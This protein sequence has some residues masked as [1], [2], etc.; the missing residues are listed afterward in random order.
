MISNLPSSW[1][2]IPLSKVCEINPRTKSVLKSDDLVSFVPMAAVSEHSGSIVSGETRPLG[3]VRKGFTPFQDGDVLFAKITPCMENGKAA[4]ARGLVNGQG[5]GSTEFHV[6]RPSSLVMAEWLF[7]IIRTA[8]FR[9]AAAASFQGAVGQQ[10]VTADFLLR[11]SIPV[12]PLSEQQR[13]VEIL[14]EAEAIRRLR[15]EAEARTAELVPAMFEASFGDPVGNP[16][17]WRIR[18]LAELIN[19]TPKNGLYKPA[20][21]YGEGTPIIRIGDFTGGILRTSK[22]LQRLRITEKEI[23]Q[24]GVSNGQI[25]INRVNS[26]EHLGKSLLVA[27][28]TEPTVYE[29]N[30]MRL[31]PKKEKVLPD[32]LIA[33]LQHPSLVAKLRAKAKKAINQASINQTDVLTLNIPVPPLSAQE[34]FVAEVEQAE[35]I[36]LLGETS[37]SLA[38]SLNA[39]LSAYAFAGELT[40]EWRETNADKL[41][42]EARERDQA[43]QASQGRAVHLSA[44]AT[45]TSKATASLILEDP[46]DGIYSDLNREQR[47][48]FGEIKRMIGGVGHIRYF[49]AK[50]VGD[51]VRIPPL[52]K[53]PQAIEGHLAALAV[54]GLLIPVSREEQT[55]DT[56]EYLFGNAYRLVRKDQPNVIQLDGEAITFNGE[57][58][59]MGSE[60]GDRSRLREME[61]LIGQLEKE[62]A[63]K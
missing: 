32:F 37:L 4:I 2:S 63:E 56:G 25:L 30:M 43:L 33:C 24:F 31:D 19:D 15:A 45:A 52:R 23:E 12:P 48:V 55:E 6:L 39:S 18:P 44:H 29:S 54:R 49:N 22:N 16:R 8:D 58:I 14:Q 59:S 10:R 17:N 35:A 1:V 38:N 62:R 27:S 53:N 47:F 46:T 34:A 21:L 9:R 51:Y 50:M 20:E 57:L 7:A 61:R 42:A 41:E 36:R 3:E 13:I 5:Y 60:P 11:F 26:I 28:L 40:A